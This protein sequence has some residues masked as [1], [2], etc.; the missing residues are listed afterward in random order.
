ME[1]L[2]LLSVGSRFSFP[3]IGI[4]PNEYRVKYSYV[5]LYLLPPRLLACIALMVPLIMSV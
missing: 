1:G 3:S 4:K 2:A 5:R